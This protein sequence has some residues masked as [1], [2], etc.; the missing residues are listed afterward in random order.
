[1]PD[2]V[3]RG[4]P[5]LPENLS[6]IL[7]PVGPR[8]ISDNASAVDYVNKRV[9]KA[10]NRLGSLYG[11]DVRDFGQSHSFAT[12]THRQGGDRVAV[13]HVLWNK[14]TGNIDD[15]QI[16]TEHRQGG[17]STAKLLQEAWNY[18]GIDRSSGPIGGKVLP[19]SAW[20]LQRAHNPSYPGF[21]ESPYSQERTSA[22]IP[23]TDITQEEYAIT[24]R[25]LKDALNSTARIL[26]RKGELI[27]PFLDTENRQ[28]ATSNEEAF[29]S[30]Q[31]QNKS[32]RDYRT[33][34]AS[35]SSLPATTTVRGTY[36]PSLPSRNELVNS[37]LVN[38]ESAPNLH[39]VEDNDTPPSV[40]PGACSYCGG[41]GHNVLSAPLDQNVVSSLA[42]GASGSFIGTFN[43]EPDVSSHPG[44]SVV[45]P[46]AG[47]RTNLIQDM[48]D[49]RGE[50]IKEVT[51]YDNAIVAKQ[52]CDTCGGSGRT[53]NA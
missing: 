46:R 6:E 25:G 41:R 50:N 43:F 21:S 3:F 1:M 31:T 13:G 32:A 53:S 35:L 44:H 5:N 20:R 11:V 34:R 9:G 33:A 10:A 37:L 8:S 22:G 14:E 15:L 24:Y 18:A 17:S 29:Q 2:N 19:A 42:R 45:H 48:D 7:A 16:V 36:S 30:R 26:D 28:M 39:R 12:L 27:R 52:T 51:V 47:E 4:N 40:P 38:P 49:L 23:S